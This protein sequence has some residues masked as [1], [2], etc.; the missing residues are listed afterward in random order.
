MF[1]LS[2][3]GGQP[4]QG[5][6]ICFKLPQVLCCSRLPPP[7]DLLRPSFISSSCCGGAAG[8]K[9][10]GVSS[11]RL[12]EQQVRE[13]ALLGLPNSAAK[14]MTSMAWY[15]LPQSGGTT[16][17]GDEFFDNQSAGWSLWSFS[18]SGDQKTTGVKQENG[19][20]QCSTGNS[21]D[22]PEAPS[23]LEELQFTQPTEDFFLSQFSDEEMRRMDAPFE[24]L[25]MFPDSMHRLLSYENMLSGVLTGSDD[26]D[27]KLDHNG[28]DTM[29]TCGFPLFIHDTQNESRNGEPSDPEVLADLSSEE[30]KAGLCMTKRSRPI[31]DTEN[32]TGFEA[33][34]LEELED[35]VFQLTKRTRICYRDAFYRLAESS[36]AKCSTANG[37]TEVGS[38]TSKQSVQQPDGN[39]SRFSTPGCPERETNPIDRTVMVLTMKPPGHQLHGSCCADDSGAEARSTTTARA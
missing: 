25:E 17:G 3:P 10:P 14:S 35:V 5:R 34:V 24:A 19:D 1:V 27:V 22:Q 15:P 37:A 12:K 9:A 8:G 20:A 30:D 23:P 16:S 26:E 2:L 4:R 28:M 21:E 6:C 18:A 29:D 11:P 13:R 39:A 31:T 38:S 7:A 33:L 32:T 36:K